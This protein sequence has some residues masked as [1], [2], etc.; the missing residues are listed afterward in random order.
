MG[1]LDEPFTTG[2]R[3]ILAKEQAKWQKKK[4]R[5]RKKHPLDSCNR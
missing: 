5:Q 1:N 2:H 3:R 4:L